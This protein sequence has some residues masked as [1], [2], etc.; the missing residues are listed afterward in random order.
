MVSR[1]RSCCPHCRSVNIWY[2][3]REH[4]HF[5]RKC[6]QHF[7]KPATKIFGQNNKMPNS[8]KRV[9]TEKENLESIHWIVSLVNYRLTIEPELILG[10]NTRLNQ[11]F[12]SNQLPILRQSWFFLIFS[13]YKLISKLFYYFALNI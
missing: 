2:V 12:G 11:K 10:T 1:L 5:C 9:L 6:K 4:H 3:R 13:L 8:L 7:S